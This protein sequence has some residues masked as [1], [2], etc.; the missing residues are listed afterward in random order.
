MGAITPI[1]NN[2]T[3]YKENLTKGK[4]GVKEISHFDTSDFNVKL[5][6]EADIDLN[7][8]FTTK[9]LNK[10]DRFS[11]FA[12]IAADEAILQSG[13]NSPNLKKERIGVIIGSGIGGM[14]TLE[15]QHLRM[16]NHPKKVSPYFIPSMITDIA[17]GHISIKYGL[18]LF[19]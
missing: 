14:N 7:D 5:A 18:T 19:G 8:H 9:E 3:D 2:I 11:S 6:A 15:N 12:L 4:N 17:S 10:L 16:L 13:I 1:G